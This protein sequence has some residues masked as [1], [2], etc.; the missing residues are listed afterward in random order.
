MKYI[1]VIASVFVHCVLRQSMTCGF[2]AHINHIK[3]FKY[4]P[5]FNHDPSTLFKTNVSFVNVK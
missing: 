4:E 2:Y 5:D 1:V 3:T